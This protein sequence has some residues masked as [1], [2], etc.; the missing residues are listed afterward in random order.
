MA[1]RMYLLLLATLVGPLTCQRQQA[2]TRFFGLGQS[3]LDAGFGLDKGA[4]VGLGLGTALGAAVLAPAIGNAIGGDQCRGCCGK[5]RR[6]QASTKYKQS[7][8]S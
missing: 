7:T 8:D 2:D 6:R 3:A 4:L 5:R 1:S